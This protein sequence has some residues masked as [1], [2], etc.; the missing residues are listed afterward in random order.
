M[1]SVFVVNGVLPVVQNLMLVSAG[2]ASVDLD[3]HAHQ[4]TSVWV[5]NVSAAHQVLFVV[6]TQTI[7]SMAS[8]RA[9]TTVFA[10]ARVTHARLGIVVVAHLA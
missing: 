3:Q 7:V 5:A 4:D 1:G 9:G 6:L 8:A 10:V 2:S